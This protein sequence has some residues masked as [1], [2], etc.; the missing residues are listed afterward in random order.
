MTLLTKNSELPEVAEGLASSMFL[1]SLGSSNFLLTTLDGPLVVFSLSSGRVAAFLL[2]RFIIADI[3]V[4]SGSSD[5]FS[6]DTLSAL[7]TF[8]EVKEW[9]PTVFGSDNLLIRAMEVF[10]SGVT[11]LLSFFGSDNDEAD[12]VNLFPGKR[13][14]SLSLLDLEALRDSLDTRDVL[15][16]DLCKGD[17]DPGSES[18]N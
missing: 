5:N 9:L 6:F 14:P 15:T 4:L 2:S 16:F 12:L 18:L 3:F 8:V 11:P 17:D 13:P 7:C 10:D 1:V